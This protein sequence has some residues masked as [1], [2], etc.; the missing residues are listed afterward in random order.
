MTHTQRGVLLI[1][2]ILVIAAVLHIA[3]T[4]STLSKDQ[5]EASVD[6]DAVDREAQRIVCDSLVAHHGGD[7]I[8]NVTANTYDP[9]PVPQDGSPVWTGLGA[10]C[11]ATYTL[12][13]RVGY[14]IKCVKG[15]LPDTTYPD[16]P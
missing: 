6:E 2:A 7:C 3:R 5:T 9:S 13:I 14:V 10:E 11:K 16:V 8:S 12:T 1:A 4:A 15:Q